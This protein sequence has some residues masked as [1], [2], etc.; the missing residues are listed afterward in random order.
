MISTRAP[1]E[2]S[3]FIRVLPFH[4]IH[5]STRA[6]RE[7]SDRGRDFDLWHSF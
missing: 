5:I 2:G 6:P 4:L 7:G 3:D 1:R